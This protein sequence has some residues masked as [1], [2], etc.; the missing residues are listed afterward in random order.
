MDFRRQNTLR[1][2]KRLGGKLTALTLCMSLAHAPYCF[3]SQDPKSDRQRL[4]TCR[5]LLESIGKPEETAKLLATLKTEHD[6][7]QIVDLTSADLNAFRSGTSNAKSEDVLVINER[8]LD[9]MQFASLLQS[10]PALFSVASTTGSQSVSALLQS[11][12]GHPEI[13]V[14]I[15]TDA[16]G[17]EKV[18][19]IPSAAAGPAVKYLEDTSEQFRALHSKMLNYALNGRPLAEVLLS[20][21][22]RQTAEPL[23]VVAHN[24]RGMLKF[25]DGSTIRIDALYHALGQ[26]RGV[27]LSCDTIH[28]EVPANNALLTNR[29]LDFRDIANGL[30]SAQG[31]LSADPNLSLGSLLF[32]FAK[33]IS[34]GA[35]SSAGTVKM[36]AMVVGGL[37]VIGL[38]YYWVCEDPT[39]APPFCP[40]RSKSDSSKKAVQ[41]NAQ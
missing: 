41:G 6:S 14:A 31:L 34:T 18:F 35:T 4:E 36:V 13:V 1:F 5:K 19:G 26:R 8:H 15:P 39:T 24:E 10:S 29:E 2:A 23:F 25:P 33:E 30:K 22:K 32:A 21:A 3:A 28:S 37:I 7:R 11:K 12:A 16:Q 20:E 38:L 17:V 27:V 9:D 40:H